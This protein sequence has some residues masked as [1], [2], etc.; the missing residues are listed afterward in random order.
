MS[1]FH[2]TP[3]RSNH[4]FG[5][6]ALWQ[7]AFPDDLPWNAAEIVIHAKVAFQPDLFL[8]PTKDDK[9]IDCHRGWISR[10]AVLNSCS[11]QGIGT[12]LMHGAEARLLSMGCRKI[13]L[14]VRATNAAVVAFYQKL[15]YSIEERISIAKR[16]LAHPT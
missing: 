13:N 14:Q 12:A 15:G 2:I 4:F 3:Y 11:R 10:I 6:K 7:E 16:L 8:V 9:V 1:D 5:V